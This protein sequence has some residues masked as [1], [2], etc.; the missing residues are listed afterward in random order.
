MSKPQTKAGLL[1]P[2]G[3]DGFE[4]QELALASSG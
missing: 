1:T 2:Q 4:P 3:V